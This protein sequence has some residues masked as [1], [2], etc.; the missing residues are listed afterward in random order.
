MPGV[1]PE[2]LEARDTLSISMRRVKG[3]WLCQHQ[4]GLR[5]DAVGILSPTL[6]DDELLLMA[7]LPRSSRPRP[8][9]HAVS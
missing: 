3:G 1:M 5:C 9:L 2:V 8:L 6:V 7:W 4:L